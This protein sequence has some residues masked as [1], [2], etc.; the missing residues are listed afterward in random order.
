MKLHIKDNTY[1]YCNKCHDQVKPCCIKHRVFIQKIP[2]EAV[3][4]MVEEKQEN[5]MKINEENDL[6]YKKFTTNDASYTQRR[7]LL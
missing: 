3:Q 6:M 5:L 1:L 7:L 4:K 2:M